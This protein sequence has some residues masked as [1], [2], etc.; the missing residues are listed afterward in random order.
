MTHCFKPFIA[1]TH[2]LSPLLSRPLAGPTMTDQYFC[3]WLLLVALALLSWRHVGKACI[4]CRR[5][6]GIEAGSFGEK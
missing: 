1:V 6:E 5:K 4:R 2:C 3:N